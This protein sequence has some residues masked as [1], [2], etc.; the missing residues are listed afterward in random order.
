MEAVHYP[1]VLERAKK[2]HDFASK[3]RE[4]RKTDR[5]EHA[6]SKGEPGEGHDSDN[7]AKF[8]ENQC[9]SAGVIHLRAQIAA[10]LT[11]HERIST[12]PH[13]SHQEC[14]HWQSRER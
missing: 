13:R 5:S 7:T 1:P 12:Q 6:K 10:Q 4:A 8:V 3:V 2:D 9:S 14:Q 11:D